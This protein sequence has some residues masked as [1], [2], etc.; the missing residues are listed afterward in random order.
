MTPSTDSVSVNPDKPRDIDV[1][2]IIVPTTTPATDIE[3]TDYTE[4]EYPDA[5]FESDNTTA[6]TTSEPK[7]EDEVSTTTV[8]AIS[9]T[10]TARPISAEEVF[11]VFEGQ[12]V[13]NFGTPKSHSDPCQSCQCVD[14]EMVCAEQKCD[15]PSQDQVC[16]HIF[17]PS[18]AYLRI[19]NP[20][21]LTPGSQLPR[22][23]G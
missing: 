5:V 12:I 14:G 6:T 23:Q 8:Q 4:L 7:I 16:Y 19:F 11:C 3:D 15:K 17:I 1:M 13:P 18:F 21:L 10:T 22:G 9:D 2:S 20:F